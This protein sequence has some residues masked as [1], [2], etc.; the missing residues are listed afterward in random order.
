MPTILITEPIAESAVAALEQKGFHVQFEYEKRDSDHAPEDVTVYFE[1]FVQE[2]ARIYEKG[3]V[4]IAPAVSQ[5]LLDSGLPLDYVSLREL[6]EDQVRTLEGDT[7][8]QLLPFPDQF[9]QEPVTGRRDLL[10]EQI[11]RLVR[12][13]CQKTEIAAQLVISRATL[14]RK[15]KKYN[16][17]AD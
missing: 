12:Q 6:A 16:L 8:E 10:E 9:V 15:L 5:T 1:R 17:T 7:L 2:F 13:G 14:Y 11:R 4:S 3:S